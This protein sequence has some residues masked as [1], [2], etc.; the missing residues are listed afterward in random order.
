MDKTQFDLLNKEQAALG[1]TLFANP[2]NVSAGSIRQL[3]PKVTAGRKLKCCIYDIVDDEKIFIS[4]RRTYSS[5][6]IWLVQVPKPNAVIVW[7]MF[8][9]TTQN[10]KKSVNHCRTGLMASWFL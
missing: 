3:D 5:K 10:G 7:K 8:W 1:K 4:R 2:R 9:R 6:K